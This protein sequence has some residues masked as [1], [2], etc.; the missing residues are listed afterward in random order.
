M[1]EWRVSVLQ[2]LTGPPLLPGPML[3][4]PLHAISLAA[5]DMERED[6]QG[7]LTLWFHENR[8]T[9]GNPSTKVFGVTNCHVLRRNPTV[10]YEHTGGAPMSYL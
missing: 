10:D 4:T 1:I 2:R 5:E 3:L 8:D 6:A 7:T 9:A